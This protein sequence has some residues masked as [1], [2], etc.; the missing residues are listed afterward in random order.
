MDRAGVDGPQLGNRQNA[1]DAF[2]GFLSGLVALGQGALLGA[3]LFAGLLHAFAFPLDH[4]GGA[5]DFLGGRRRARIDRISLLE[6]EQGVAE[7]SLGTQFESFI[8]V[9]LGGLEVDLG[10]R[11]L[12]DD[13]GRVF[14]KRLFVVCERRVPLFF[15]F[16]DSPIGQV[17]VALFGLGFQRKH[18]AE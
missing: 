12:V 6:F 4:F 14:G 8:D 10:G 2:F 5:A 18:G 3:G 7:L 9:G 16:V 15:L 17:F 1:G 13:L 11:H